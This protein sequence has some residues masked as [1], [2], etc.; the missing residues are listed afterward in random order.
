MGDIFKIII[1]IFTSENMS[2]EYLRAIDAFQNLLLARPKL[3][4]DVVEILNKTKDNTY[5]TTKEDTSENENENENEDEQADNDTKL[6]DD[7]LDPFQFETKKTNF[8]IRDESPFTAHFQSIYDAVEL[9]VIDQENTALE[10]NQYYF[11]QFVVDIL[12]KRFLPYAFI[13]SSLTLRDP[14]YIMDRWTN[15]TVERFIGTRKNAGKNAEPAEYIIKSQKSALANCKEYIS[16]QE[17]EKAPKTPKKQLPK[18]PSK[19]PSKTP[20]KTPSKTPKKVTFDTKDEQSKTEA[21][22]EWGPKKQPQIIVPAN[23]SKMAFSYQKSKNLNLIESKQS[24]TLITKEPI[25]LNENSPD[26]VVVE[27][28]YKYPNI[29]IELPESHLKRLS[30]NSTGTDAWLSD[31]LLEILSRLLVKNLSN[32]KLS[33]CHI[34]T[35]AACTKIFNNGDTENIYRKIALDNY[36]YVIGFYEED[37]HWRLCFANMPNNIFY[38]VDPYKAIKTTQKRKLE[39]WSQFVSSKSK[40]SNKWTLGDFKHSKQTDSYNCGVICLLFL[41]N[42]FLEQFNCEYDDKI[43]IDYRK[44]LY[45]LLI[46]YEKK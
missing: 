6:N 15:G 40:S 10:K 31:T 22:S 35:T 41:E 21:V 46:K 14:T 4:E 45:D 3:R 43:L 44:K 25:I 29:S 2:N 17:Q 36:K 7:F 11:P 33:D 38:Y 9:D 19:T 39:T 1:Q 34:M 16:L 37:K 24:S 32:I 5:E 8:V 27:K 18:T 28:T 26:H 42:L 12:L 30:Q 23:H 20:T 13:W